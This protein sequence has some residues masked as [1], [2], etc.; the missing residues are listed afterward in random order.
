MNILDYR[1][2]NIRKSEKEIKIRRN[3]QI[4]SLRYELEIEEASVEGLHVMGWN[5]RKEVQFQ[6]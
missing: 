6:S 3:I 1:D 2:R 5:E 4:E